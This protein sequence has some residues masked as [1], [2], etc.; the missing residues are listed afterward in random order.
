M[1]IIKIYVAGAYSASTWEDKQVNTDKAVEIGVQLILKGHN[2]FIPHLTHYVDKMAIDNNI[3][4]PWEKWIQIDDEWLCLCDGFLLIS[5]SR[6][7]DM[8]LKRAKELGKKIYYSLD[9][10]K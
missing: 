4:I 8:E 6:G 3:N 1:L 5:H 7:A 9:E 2:P 10:I